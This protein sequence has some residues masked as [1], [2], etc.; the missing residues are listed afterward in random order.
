MSIKSTSIS[1]ARQQSVQSKSAGFI[2][3]A[4]AYAATGAAIGPSTD[5]KRYVVVPGQTETIQ[6]IAGGDAPTIS[7][8]VVTDENW[9][10]T[11]LNV[12]D[13]LTGGYI[14]INGTG[15]D[16]GT[17][18][19]LNAQ[20]IT[21]IFVNSTLL[22]VEVPPSAIGTYSLMIFT[23]TG[24]GVIYLNLDFSSTPAFITPAGSIGSFYELLPFSV[25][26][27]A[28]AD[29]VI[30]YS[31]QSG[32]LPANVTLAANGVISGNAPA[33]TDSTV[34]SIVVLAN[35]EENQQSTRSFNFTILPD[36]ITWYS[37]SG[38]VTYV[39]PTGYNMTETS[40]NITLNARAVSNSTV[41][42]TANAVPTGLT[43]N[44]NLI[45]GTPSVQ[46]TVYSLIT[47]TTEITNKA[48]S[49]LTTFKIRDTFDVNNYVPYFSNIFPLPT[50]TRSDFQF[51][52]PDGTKY[53]TGDQTSEKVF[54]FEMEANN[55]ATLTYQA[56]L[57]ITANGLASSNP[58]D[59]H[60]KPDGTKLF[61]AADPNTPWLNEYVLSEPW[62]VNTAVFVA[63]LSLSPASA[64]SID[65]I[66]FANSGQRLYTTTSASVKE[67]ELST[68]WQINT[69]VITARSVSLPSG[70]T[71]MQVSEDG[72]ILW[73]ANLSTIQKRVMTIPFNINTAVLSQSANTLPQFTSFANSAVTNIRNMEVSDDGKLIWLIADPT[74]KPIIFNYEM[75]TPNDLTSFQ[76]KEIGGVCA[77]QAYGMDIKP[78]GTKFYVLSQD[79]DDTVWQLDLLRPYDIGSAVR[80]GTF[81]AL[82]INQLGLQLGNNGNKL[83]VCNQTVIREHNLTTP[84]QV[85]SAILVG[86]LT[87][88]TQVQ[89][90]TFSANG[91]RM[92]IANANTDRLIEYALPTPWQVNTA[93]LLANISVSSVDSIMTDLHFNSFGNILF[94]IGSSKE[95][96]YQFNLSTPWQL[97]TAVY[98]GNTYVGNYGTAP[99]S[100][101][102]DSLGT[103]LYWGDSTLDYVWQW[104]LG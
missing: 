20:S 97:N 77:V 41:S 85:N 83:Y 11:G 95:N 79:D 47:A 21:T 84:W 102:M 48:N 46:E 68:P 32:S 50:V 18:V 62:N 98:V 15:F 91:H 5:I 45:S 26:V 93:V 99:Q 19:Y 35:D 9:V 3:V 14:E 69:A 67:W 17:T 31:V 60:F 56:E 64:T 44:G 34:F 101:V 29:S 61:V 22:R 70:T 66:S 33:V 92:Y 36:L 82:L 100:L 10:P 55:F 58:A 6:A 43:L 39:F 57:A 37:P 24:A 88:T 73:S 16:S 13:N 38:N 8:I 86:S 1:S 71:S 7:S 89:D 54:Q 78:D 52:S 96:I 104:K 42:Y 59:V 51:I 74:S 103:N 87:V 80:V 94:T 12:I 2:F 28:N 75:I 81:R 72:S 53:Y 27:V 30:T 25:N 49:I 40:G 4:N 23:S 90:F 65:A 63:N 76:Y